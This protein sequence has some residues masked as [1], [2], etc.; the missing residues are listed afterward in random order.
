MDLHFQNLIKNIRA[1]KIFIILTKIVSVSSTDENSNN[2][3]YPFQVLLETN[4]PVMVLIDFG[5]N[6][7]KNKSFYSGY[8][9]EF[10]SV[11]EQKNKL[12]E[13]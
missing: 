3:S 9:Q 8:C 12:L 7:F 1:I 4:D 10:I 13:I 2:F 11:V 5:E 6:E